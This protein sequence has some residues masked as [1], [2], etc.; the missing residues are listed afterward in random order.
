MVLADNVSHYDDTKAIFDYGFT[1]FRK[2]TPD[3]EALA[4]AKENT[5]GAYLKENG[6][7][8]AVVETLP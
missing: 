6:L 4:P 7:L 3:N 8:D 1:N 5:L 2:L